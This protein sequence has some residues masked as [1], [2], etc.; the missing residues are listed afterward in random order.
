MLC[1]FIYYTKFKK[2]FSLC[3]YVTMHKHD[4]YLTA[5]YVATTLRISGKRGAA[6]AGSRWTKV[7]RITIHRPSSSSLYSSFTV[8]H[9]EHLQN[10]CIYRHFNLN[11]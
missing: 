6:S 7:P 4:M 5:S 2:K 8:P 3:H 1:N 11:I 10:K 9:S